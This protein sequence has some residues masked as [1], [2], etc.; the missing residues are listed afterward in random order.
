M[1]LHNSINVYIYYTQK[2]TWGR[3]WHC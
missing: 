2:G 1:V 3:I